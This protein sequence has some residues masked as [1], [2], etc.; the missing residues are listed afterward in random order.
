MTTIPVYYLRSAL[1][2]ILGHAKTIAHVEYS[3]YIEELDDNKI[4]KYSEEET[5]W[6]DKKNYLIE[7]GFD[8]TDRKVGKVWKAIHDY[9]EPKRPFTTEPMQEESEDFLK[10]LHKRH[11]DRT[12]IHLDC[13]A[14]FTE[15]CDFV[16]GQYKPKKGKPEVLKAADFKI[17]STLAI[18][19]CLLAKQTVLDNAR[20]IEF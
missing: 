8:I 18:G 13:Y 16:K 7:K 20:D 4:G 6:L 11:D 19:V 2:F 12:K 5:I 15:Y 9:W 1:Y 10:F 17:D 14:I 3:E